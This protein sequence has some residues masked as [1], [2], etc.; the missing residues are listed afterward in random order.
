MA[1]FTLIQNAISHDTIEAARTILDQAEQG[2]ALGF[3]F[4]IMYREKQYVVNAAGE[5][6]DSPTFARGMNAALDDFL[7]DRLHELKAQG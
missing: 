7:K 3:I 1:T 4:G 6:Y 5:A 2:V